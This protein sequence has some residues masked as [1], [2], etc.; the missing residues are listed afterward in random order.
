[1]LEYKISHRFLLTTKPTQY[2]GERS[3]LHRQLVSMLILWYDVNIPTSKVENSPQVWS[4]WLKSAHVSDKH[5]LHIQ[6][7][8]IRN[9]SDEMHFMQPKIF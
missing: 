5:V 8:K 6:K 2:L 1:M 7:L 3:S 9:N 4:C